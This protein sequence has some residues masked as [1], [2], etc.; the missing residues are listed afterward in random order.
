MDPFLSITDRALDLDSPIFVSDNK[1]RQDDK[2][3]LFVFQSLFCLLLFEATFTFFSK[4]KVIKKSQN[5]RNQGFSY[6]LCLMVEGSG[7]GSIP[8]T[9]GPGS[10]A[11]R[12]KTN[13]S[14]SVTLSLLLPLVVF[15]CFPGILDAKETLLGK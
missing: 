14:G 12:L 9:N 4:S 13:G 2:S 8:R 15:P 10:G 7:T 6:Y 5:G 1:T 11:R 3:K